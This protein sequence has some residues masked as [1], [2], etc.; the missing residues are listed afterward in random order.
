VCYAPFLPE[1]PILSVYR[2]QNIRRAKVLALAMHGACEEISI[3]SEEMLM[4][5]MER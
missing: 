2:D 3:K 5:F 1:L 4:H